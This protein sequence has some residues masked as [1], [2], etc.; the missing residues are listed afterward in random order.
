MSLLNS[1]NYPKGAWVLN[2]LRGLVGDSAFFGGIREYYRRYRNGTSLSADFA[3][4]VSSAAG[5]DL[6][7]YFRQALTQPGYPILDVRWREEKGGLGLVIRQTQD[8]AWGLFTLPGLRIL[9]D[10]KPF[11]ID[12]SGRETHVVLAGAS[13]HPRTLVIDPEAWWLVKATVSDE[14][15]AVSGER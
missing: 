6:D 14:K 11:A 9:V 15:A 8:E 2:S 7:W 13:L 3:R 12:V 5:R 10:G 4:V 1:N